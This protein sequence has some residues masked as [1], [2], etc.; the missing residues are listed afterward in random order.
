MEELIVISPDRLKEIIQLVLKEELAKYSLDKTSKECDN[1][2][3]LL[4]FKEAQ[5][6]LK[7]SRPTLYARMKDQSIPFKKL[8]NRILFSKHDIV[9]SLNSRK[10][11][12]RG[13]N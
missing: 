9:A 6:F 1:D 13:L 5:R 8:G 12:R 10:N 2:E 3:V 4:N 7:I 11:A